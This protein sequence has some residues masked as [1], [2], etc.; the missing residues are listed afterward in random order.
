MAVLSRRSQ[1]ATTRRNNRDALAAATLELLAEGAAFADASIEQIVRR[2]GLSRPTFYSHFAD[3]RALILHLGQ[4]LL[5][6]V[7]EAADPWLARG[8]GEVRPT[9][10]AVLGAFETHRE[11]LLALVEAAGYDVEVNAFWHDFHDRF[12]AAAV[13]RIRLVAPDLSPQRARA[14]GFAL[15]WMTERTATE[16]VAGADVDRTALLDELTGFWERALRGGDD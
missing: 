13:E 16:L 2:A 5:D 1:A 10:D 12:V 8:E 9:L 15:V 11:T 7:A 6:A 3:K 14:R 4:G